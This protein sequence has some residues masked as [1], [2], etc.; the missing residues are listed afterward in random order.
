[1]PRLFPRAV[2]CVLCAAVGLQAQGTS[3]P[4]ATYV[5]VDMYATRDD[6][7][8]SD[9]TLD[10]IEVRE[11]GVAQA[12]D[13]FEYVGPGALS[14]DG[15][16]L[17]VFLDTRHSQLEGSVPMRQALV[18]LLD[19]LVRADDLVGVIT[20]EMAPSDLQLR[21]KDA[22]VSAIQQTEWTWA[23]RGPLVDGLDQKEQ[24]YASCYGTDMTAEG[25][26]AQMRARHREKVALDAIA[27]LLP[28][29]A[30]L[31]DG[32]KA[33]LTVT[34]GW[35]LVRP[36]DVLG[37]RSSSAGRSGGRRGSRGVGA[38]EATG[39]NRV[40]CEA[41]RTAL[42]AIDHT[43]RLREIAEEANRGNVT[44]YPVYAPGLG[45]DPTGAEQSRA[46][47]GLARVRQDSLGFLA[48]ETDGTTIM[49]PD[50]VEKGLARIDADL[51]S[52]Y[53]LGYHSSNTKLDGRFR[54][55]TVRVDRPGVGVR[56]RRG[57]R[58]LTVEELF[59]DAGDTRPDAGAAAARATEAAGR[60]PFSVRTSSWTRDLDGESAGAFWLVGE[61]DYRT[62]RELAWTAGATVDVVV[63]AADGT[64]IMTRTLDVRTADG[65]F[66][67][68]VPASGGLVPGEYAV[69]VRL[70]SEAD[71]EAVLSDTVRVVLGPGTALGE[72]VLW[73]RGPTTGLAHQRT[74]SLRFQ[75]NERLRLELPTAGSG[76]VTT[77]LL[78]RA[79]NPVPVPIEIDQRVDPS[80][81]FGWLVVDVSLA[82]FAPGEYAVE[83]TQGDARQLTSF[84]IVP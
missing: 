39:L 26:A 83:V 1:M 16:V 71:A 55:I 78:D 25:V 5:R 31:R 30:E 69:R 47:A 58:G 53:L 49:R 81:R 3:A 20:P 32:R 4:G 56:A 2:L 17:V 19:R 35:E 61:L 76:P 52:Y 11:D 48:R 66:G 6:L 79:G 54:T 37:A 7:P 28:R 34:D 8:V 68:E 50:D 45:S 74:A 46:A 44:F 42:A 12:V 72:P 65:A 51:E 27:R 23:R 80:A 62:R 22:A 73:R 24:L 59:S 75:R 29:V 67:I 82:P 43:S 9:L 10:E 41:D 36:S 63:V 21:P 40:E 14:R 18:G 84:R 15:R 57:Y 77:R 64:E 60:S 13:S 33:V 70:T 38:T